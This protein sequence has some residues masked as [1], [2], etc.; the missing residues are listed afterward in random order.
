MSPATLADLVLLLHFTFILFVLFGG[1]LTLYRRWFALLHVPMFLWGA[2]VNLYGWPCPLTPLENHYRQLAGE[3][4]YQGG[5]VEHY[6]APLVYP[7]GLTQEM[8][9]IVGSGT[10]L[11]NAAIYAFVLLRR[12]SGSS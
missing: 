9:V 3:A 12:R 2:L 5:F 4:A 1:L 7:Q 11:W 10:L 6:I 8:G